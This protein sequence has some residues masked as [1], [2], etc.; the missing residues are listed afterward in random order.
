MDVTVLNYSISREHI[1]SVHRVGCKD[2]ERDAREH[3][4]IQ[5]G[6]FASVDAAL[7]SE[8]LGTVGDVTATAVMPQL[9]AAFGTWKNT[10]APPRVTALPAAPQHTAR[11][12]YL[13][14]KPNAPQS[15]IRIGWIGV[16][17]ST[18]ISTSSPRS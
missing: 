14:D 8:I 17:R 18:P 2:I 16:P 6:P 7:A 15:Q 12:I 13:V 4:A 10:A 11:Q 9:E 1:A 5:Y 3:A